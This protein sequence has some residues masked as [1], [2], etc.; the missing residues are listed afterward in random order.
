MSFK[1]RNE[2][3]EDDYNV[4]KIV[5]AVFGPGRFA[6]TAYRLREQSDYKVLFGLVTENHLGKIVATVR[7]AQ[8]NDYENTAI[9]GPIAV[10]PDLRNIG[11]GMALMKECEKYCQHFHIKRII[12]VG[13][14]EYYSRFGYVPSEAY[15]IQF[16]GPVNKKRILGKKLVNG[17]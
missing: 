10:N 7:V 9:L 12:L 4:E 1:I 11:L 15:D 16:P 14:P 8:M 5:S 3:P 2:I 17:D 13:D 6:K